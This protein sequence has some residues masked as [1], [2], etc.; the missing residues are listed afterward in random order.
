MK[1]DMGDTHLFDADA[2]DIQIRHADETTHIASTHELT[3]S[4]LSR[5]KIFEVETTNIIPPSK[6]LYAEDGTS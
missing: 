6:R 5:S 3:I 2:V 4:R 1:I